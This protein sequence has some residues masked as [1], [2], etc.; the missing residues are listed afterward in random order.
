MKA[1]LRHNISPFSAKCC[2]FRVPLLLRR[3]NPGAYGPD[4]VSIGPLHSRREKKFQATENVKQWY[5]HNLL[6]RMNISLEIFIERIGKVL[7]Q[8]KECF[9]EFDTRARDFYAEPLDHINQDDFIEMMILDGCFIMEFFR[10][11]YYK[12]RRDI[13]DPIFNMDCMIQYLFH[14][15][16]LLENQLPWFVLERLYNLTRNYDEPDDTALIVLMLKAFSTHPPLHHNSHSYLCYLYDHGD[17]ISHTEKKYGDDKDGEAVVVVDDDNDDDDHDDGLLHILDLIRTSIVFPFKCQI[18][19]SFEN[20]EEQLIPTATALSEAGVK[21]RKGT[22]ESIMNIQF[23]HGVFTIPQ[24]AIGELTESIFR[25]LIAL[26]QCYHG[27]SPKITSYAVLMDNLICSSRDMKL[28]CENEVLGKWLSPEDGS[29]FFNKLYNDTLLR[30]FYYS[31][32]CFRVNTYYGKGWSK[33]LEILNREYLSNPWK[34][35][36]LVAACILLVLTLLQT[37]Y[38][39]HQ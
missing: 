10:N 26:E 33:W 18:D 2:I 4:I 7:D 8:E 13:N 24:L 39:V 17:K 15:L 32:L 12:E 27:R 16:L 9:A 3:H 28:L 36:S 37:Y 11:F 34:I 35:I 29:Q 6:S 38:T 5:L 25:N 23:K 31:E 22:A 30:K 19:R 14:D 1:K 20:L 21:F